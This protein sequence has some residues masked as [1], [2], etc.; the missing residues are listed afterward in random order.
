MKLATRLN[1]FSQ[2][3]ANI[4]PKRHRV[5]I[6]TLNDV[7]VVAKPKLRS[8]GSIDTRRKGQHLCKKST[9]PVPRLQA[10]T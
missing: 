1:T 2:Q 10:R 8:G 6:V 4:E 3:V 9:I 7:T 5:E